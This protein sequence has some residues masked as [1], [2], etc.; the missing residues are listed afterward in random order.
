MREFK[1]DDELDVGV[2]E[3]AEDRSHTRGH[4]RK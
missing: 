2:L 4:S 3:P 1:G